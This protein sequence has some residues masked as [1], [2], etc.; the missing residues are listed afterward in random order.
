MAGNKGPMVVGYDGS[1]AS[2][3]AVDWAA[4]EAARRGQDLVLLFAADMSGLY[5]PFVT[6]GVSSDFPQKM[7]HVIAQAGVAR[8]RAAAP[9]VSVDS[10]ITSRDAAVALTEASAQ[11]SLLVVGGRGRSRL[12][13]ALLGTVQFAVTAHARCPVAVVPPGCHNA[14]DADH[15]VIVGV[16]GSHGSDQAL[17][18]AAATAT[19]WAVPLRVVG[20]WQTPPVEHWSHFNVIDEEWREEMAIAVRLAATDSVTAA[21]QAA[22]EEHPNLEVREVTVEGRPS[23]V[24]ANESDDASLVVVGARG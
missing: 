13:E 5:R 6:Q 20:A 24:L 2:E 7:A 21:A 11:A 3:W 23:T 18:E 15:P 10:K 4:V 8:A 1:P 19:S 14:P 22:R 16:D 17:R 12:S 9:G